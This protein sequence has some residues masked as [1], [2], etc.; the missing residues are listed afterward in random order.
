M[1]AGFEVIRAV[2]EIAGVGIDYQGLKAPMQG[3]VALRYMGF[4]HIQQKNLNHPPRAQTR[5]RA[6]FVVLEGTLVLGR[7]CRLRTHAGKRR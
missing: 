4:A 2:Q 7:H 6:F 5:S 3:S 1:A